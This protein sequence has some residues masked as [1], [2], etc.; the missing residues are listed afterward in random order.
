M[1]A[2]PI[3]KYDF[4]RQFRE[5]GTCAI[6]ARRGS[7]KS[8]LLIDIL[9]QLRNRFDFWNCIYNY[10]ADGTDSITIYAA[11]MHLYKLMLQ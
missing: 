7:G 11:S 6:V 8:V 1:E 5:H 2:V 10:N 9:Y 3:T 4:S